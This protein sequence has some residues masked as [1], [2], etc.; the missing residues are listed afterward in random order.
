MYK[1]KTRKKLLFIMMAAVLFAV[2]ICC[3]VFAS[4]TEEEV[5]TEQAPATEQ[6]SATEPTQAGDAA[7]KQ[8]QSNDTKSGAEPE[9]TI[10]PSKEE[11][12]ESSTNAPEDVFAKSEVFLTADKSIIRT[13]EA[14]SGD[15]LADA[16]K[17][18]AQDISLGNISNDNLIAVFNAGTIRA[19]I[20]IGDIKEKDIS[21]MLPFG[22]TLSVLAVKGSDL[23]EALEASTFHAPTTPEGPF[24]QVAGID[25]TIN[26]ITPYDPQDEA[27]PSST[28]FGPKTI[29]RVTINSINGKA[30]NPNAVYKVATNNFLAAGGDSYYAFT[31]STQKV[32]TDFKLDQIAIDYIKGPLNKVIDKRYENPQGRIHE[33]EK[34]Y[35]VTFMDGDNVYISKKVGEALK[36]VKPED[37]VKDG[38]VFDGWYQ[39]KECTTA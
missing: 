30:F 10:T 15:F 26:I 31:R 12:K 25:Y 8:D 28:Y 35:M 19:G 5:E 27:Y 14:N 7:D 22:N 1:I 9:K 6:T 37:P 24:P 11:S 17:W 13:Q 36:V 33:V 23:L 34:E 4:A 3:V 18:K 16:L 20:N 39:D 38:F 32:M 2:T 29:N 21:T